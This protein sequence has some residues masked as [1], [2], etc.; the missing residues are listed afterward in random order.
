MKRLVASILLPT[1]AWAQG[2]SNYSMFGIG[3]LRPSVGALYDGAN[4][5]AVALPSEYG[6]STVNPALWTFVTST[7]LQGGYRFHQQRISS[8]AG[9][10]AQNNGKV[11]G[12]LLVFAVD[13]S[14]GWSVGTG[15][16]PLT[17]VNATA[18]VP[19]RAVVLD[20]TLVGSYR[21]LAS[22]GIT[23]AHLGIATKP[24]RTVGV[25]LSVRYYFGLFQTERVTQFLDQW[26]APDTQTVTDWL[27][28][29]GM[30]AGI[31]HRPHPHWLWALAITIPTALSTQQ[32][33]RYAYPHT[34][35]DTTFTREFHWSLPASIAG[36][37]SY[38]HG[39]LVVGAEALYADLRRL[40]YRSSPIANFQP[41]YSLSA[42]L[43]RTASP[44]EGRSYWDR[45]GVAVGVRWSRLYY[46]VHG[47]SIS[48]YALSGGLS[49]PLGTAAMLDVACQ[50][51]T[52]GRNIPRLVQE[53]FGRFSFTLSLGEQWFL[54]VRRR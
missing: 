29:V 36:G 19:L 12:L 38:H 34:F 49:L 1:L 39:R 27:S 9:S 28:G 18:A 37:I 25:G 5:S 23:V 26:S 54:P 53:R 47:H 35:A 43:L 32:V 51:G 2:G 40:D 33:W 52:R 14:K 10:V 44:R 17:S 16:Y 46:R 3:D 31:W 15:F 30:S 4:S 22:G 11:E 42:S 20:D 50:V 13:T 6:I 21:V 41:L 45:I 8:Q 48:E 7:R 24:I